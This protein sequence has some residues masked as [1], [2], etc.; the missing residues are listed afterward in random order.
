MFQT[1]SKSNFVL[2]LQTYLADSEFQTV[3][4]MTKEEF[5]E[6]PRWKQELQ[7]KKA[8]LFWNMAGPEWIPS[9]LQNYTLLPLLF[10]KRAHAFQRSHHVAMMITSSSFCCFCELY[11][12]LLYLHTVWPRYIGPWVPWPLHYSELLP[13]IACLCVCFLCLS[14]WCKW[15]RR[16]YFLVQLTLLVRFCKVMMHWHQG[17]WNIFLLR[18]KLL[19]SGAVLWV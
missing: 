9:I 15:F 19:L 10:Q 5:Y 2:I 6:Q 17:V 13:S 12:V 18:L 8:D 1:I 4:V 11:R 14:N 7:K 3:F 16:N